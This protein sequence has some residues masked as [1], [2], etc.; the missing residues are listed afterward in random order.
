MRI[1]DFLLG[2]EPFYKATE[3]TEAVTLLRGHLG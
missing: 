3:M 1:A 2:Y